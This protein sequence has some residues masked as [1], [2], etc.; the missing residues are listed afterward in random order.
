MQAINPIKTHTKFG[1]DKINTFPS[2][3]DIMMILFIC[4][5]NRQQGS[6]AQI[7]KFVT[8]ILWQQ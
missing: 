2:G 8:C 3:V 4:G 7:P 1:K 6:T 5:K